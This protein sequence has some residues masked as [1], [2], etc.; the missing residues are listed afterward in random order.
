MIQR[1]VCVF[2][3]SVPLVCGQ[4]LWNPDRPAQPLFTD[5]TARNVG[6]VLSIVITEKQT[7]K[8]KENTNLKT[9]A[10]LDAMISNFDVLPNTFNPLP[11]MAGSDKR[12]FTGTA[13]YDKEG[14]FDTKLSVVVIDVQPNGNLVVEGKKRVTIDQETKMMRITG[15][16]RPYDVLANNSVESW[17][18]ANASVAYEGTGPLTNHTNRGWLGELLDFLWPF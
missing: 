5:T 1:I 14:S 16:V 2:L 11:H 13:Q 8:N 6:D 15:I 17:Q 12:D 18:V 7:V 4:S 10:S 3:A 9:D